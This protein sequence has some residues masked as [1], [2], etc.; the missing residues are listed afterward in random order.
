M[1]EIYLFSFCPFFVFL[2]YE[3]ADHSGLRAEECTN[4]WHGTRRALLRQTEGRRF[5]PLLLQKQCFPCLGGTCSSPHV[6]SRAPPHVQ[7]TVN[8]R[9]NAARL[10]LLAVEIKRWCWWRLP[11]FVVFEYFFLLNMCCLWLPSYV[12]VNSNKMRSARPNWR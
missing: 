5:T 2:G 9:V 6:P 1:E 8:H 12:I 7:W 3:T 11:Y 10:S 4:P